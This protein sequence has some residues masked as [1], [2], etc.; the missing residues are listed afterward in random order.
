MNE[1]SKQVELF[2]KYL[3]AIKNG[4]E[5]TVRNYSLDLK[6]FERYVISFKKK[7]LMLRLSI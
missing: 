7:K 5:H 2:I 4:S 1:Y 6:A 3:R